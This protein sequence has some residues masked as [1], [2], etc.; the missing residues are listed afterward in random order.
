LSAPAIPESVEQVLTPEWMTAALSTRYPDIEVTAVIPGDSFARLSTNAMFSIETARPRPDDLPVDLCVKGYFGESIS[1]ASGGAFEGRFYR[2]YAGAIGVKTLPHVYA[3]GT[4][5]NGIVITEDVRPR[6]WTF[7]E[8]QFPY[9]PDLLAQSLSQYARLHTVSAS[10]AVDTD[11]DGDWLK[12]RMPHY[13]KA[14]G[15]KEISGNYNGPV[16]ANLPPEGR[17]PQRVVDAFVAYAERPEVNGTGEL[18]HGDAHIGNVFLDETG[19]PGLLDWQCVQRGHWATDVAYHMG[20]ALETP[21]REANE[22]DL[23]RHYLDERRRFGVETPTWED[24]W[25]D[26]RR[27]M[28]YGLFMWSVSITESVGLTST[29]IGRMT[30]AAL[31]LDTFTMLGQ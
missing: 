20:T 5:T 12:G 21:T 18:I 6:G 19:R 30:A 3:D 25:T 2:D 22:R 8:Y 4:L 11:T 14:R 7:V 17:N 29:R 23:L 26:Y 13:T 27:A 10:S 24:A 1:Y 31:A 9:T 16:G 15:L 28:I